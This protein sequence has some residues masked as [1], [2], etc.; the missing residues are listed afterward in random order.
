M[1][2]A[3]PHDTVLGLLFERRATRFVSGDYDT[4]S[5]VTTSM[6]ENPSRTETMFQGYSVLQICKWLFLYSINTILEPHYS[7]SYKGTQHECPC[8]SA[9]GECTHVFL[10]LE[11][12]AGCILFCTTFPS[13][14][15]HVQHN[16]KHSLDSEQLPLTEEEPELANSK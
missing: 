16:L 13:R 5:S 10:L 15:T 1:T 4:T 6:L 2:S 12:T 9:I 7:K 3:V 14:T 8:T 11:H